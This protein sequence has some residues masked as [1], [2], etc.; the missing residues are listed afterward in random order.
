MRFSQI[1][2]AVGPLIFLIGW[3]LFRFRRDR[4]IK[5]TF[6]VYATDDPLLQ[7]INEVLHELSAESETFVFSAARYVD[8]TLDGKTFALL[9]GS[10]G[11]VV[12]GS[13]GPKWSKQEIFFSLAPDADRQWFLT[14]K[15]L[16]TPIY[17]GVNYGVY[18]ANAKKITAAQNAAG[19]SAVR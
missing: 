9:F 10:I 13:G 14:R 3:M 2:H 11:N 12:I 15:D 1:V 16:F 5:K 17:S 8:I 4:F 6:P 19:L 7:Q 18:R